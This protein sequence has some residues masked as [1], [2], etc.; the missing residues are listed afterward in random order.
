[1]MRI[2]LLGEFSGFY[3]NLYDGLKELGQ[4][5]KIA[6][7]GDGWKKIGQS[8]I[9][10]FSNKK[11]KY[12]RAIDNTII[13][14][15]NIKE[16]KNYD[17]VQLISPNIFGMVRF[18]YNQK[19]I[20]QIKKN[21]NDLFLTVAGDHYYIYEESKKLKYSYFEH[22]YNSENKFN[23]K[24]YIKNNNDIVEMVDGIIPTMYT[25]AEAYRGH[26]KLL[27]TIP[28]PMNIDK[29]QF[30]PQKIQ[31]NKLKIFHGLN[32]EEAK[33]T[34][35]IKEAMFKIKEKYPN[36]VDIL[37]EGKMPLAKYIKVLEE[38]NVVIDQALSYE[39]GM[40]AVYSM[41]MGKV[42]LSG[43]EPEC[44][45]EF[46]RNDIPIIN[47]KPNVE[48]IYNKLEK[49]ILDKKSVEEIGYNSRQFVEDFHNYVIVAQQ[50]VD[51]WNS[52][53]SK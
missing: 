29:I 2:L 53:K 22:I 51:T 23:N 8:D 40:N 50:Y 52:C 5:V 9:K 21:N 36:D 26:A 34:K 37:I 3:N 33:G 17:V 32:R 7:G 6:S 30:I 14:F 19:L 25:Y 16:I 31:N 35:Y 4:E 10:L 18:D 44:Q 38:T 1:M 20:R 43:N 39:Y 48:D 45:Q 28:F 41:A 12:I 24:N 47:I 15:K 42:V 11:N 27:K 13:Q 46:N 49:L